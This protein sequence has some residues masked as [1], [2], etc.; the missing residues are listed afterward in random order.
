MPTRQISGRRILSGFRRANLSRPGSRVLFVVGGQSSARTAN[1][2]PPVLVAEKYRG[3][4]LSCPRATHVQNHLPVAFCQESRTA[5]AGTLPGFR[6]Y[7]FPVGV[8]V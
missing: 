6:K 7:R 8:H 4:R 1:L 5:A 3:L 2:F